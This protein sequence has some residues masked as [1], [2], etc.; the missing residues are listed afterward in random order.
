MARAW[1]IT[2]IGYVR[3]ERLNVYAG[4]ERLEFIR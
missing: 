3:G 4:E 2:L 1:G